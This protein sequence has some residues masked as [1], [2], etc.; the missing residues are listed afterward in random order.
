MNMFQSKQEF[1]RSYISSFILTKTKAFPLVFMD[2]LLLLNYMG[3]FWNLFK[4]IS[5]PC[6]EFILVF[7]KPRT[8]GI[9]KFF[10]SFE[11]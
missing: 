4:M 2:E 6:G 5:C 3:I 9:N 7:L 10:S 1:T 8:P 11:D